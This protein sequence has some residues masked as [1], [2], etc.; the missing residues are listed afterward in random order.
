MQGLVSSRTANGYSFLETK[1]LK[2]NMDFQV[3]QTNADTSLME[4]E[5]GSCIQF[6]RKKINTS[7]ITLHGVKYRA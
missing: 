1:K 3:H 7:N 4:E 5:Q 6:P 2:Q